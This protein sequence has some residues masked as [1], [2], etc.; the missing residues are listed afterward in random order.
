MGII[1]LKRQIRTLNDVIMPI[2]PTLR[3]VRRTVM[4]E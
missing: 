2:I 4:A 1:E 3:R